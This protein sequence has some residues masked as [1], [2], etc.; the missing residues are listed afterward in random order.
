MVKQLILIIHRFIVCHPLFPLRQR[1]MAHYVRW[2]KRPH[3]MICATICAAAVAGSCLVGVCTSLL[4]N[5]LHHDL[6]I[7]WMPAPADVFKDKNDYLHRVSYRYN[8]SAT[9]EDFNPRHRVNTSQWFACSRSI[10][11]VGWWD[12]PVEPLAS[13]MR[14]VRNVSSCD[15]TTFGTLEASEEGREQ[16]HLMR[17][18]NA[19]VDIVI[20]WNWGAAVE[21]ME[22]ARKTFPHQVSA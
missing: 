22:L 18:L 9:L 17:H 11:L 13:F 5:T 21:T 3:S 12:D 19:S 16:E 6:S 4:N 14:A 1:K 15:I 7:N 10:M 2:R 8:Q 20:W